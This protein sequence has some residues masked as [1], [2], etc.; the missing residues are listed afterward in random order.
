MNRSFTEVSHFMYACLSLVMV[1]NKKA[2]PGKLWA[3][4]R[5]NIV[6]GST[7][8]ANLYLHKK[9]IF[10]CAWE[11]SRGEK[12][13]GSQLQGWFFWCVV[14][15]LSLSSLFRLLYQ[16]ALALPHSR[17]SQLSCLPAFLAPGQL[18]SHSQAPLLHQLPLNLSGSIGFPCAY[19]AYCIR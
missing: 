16:F 7:S 13:L 8:A 2:V 18:H 9:K 19:F 11:R 4:E 15:H 1:G 10:L 5:E 3:L 6:R 14:R 17:S 12:C